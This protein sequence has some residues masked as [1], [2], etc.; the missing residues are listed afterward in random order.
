MEAGDHDL[1]FAPNRLAPGTYFV[2]VRAD[3]RSM[4]RTVIFVR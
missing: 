3:G 4:Q 2:Q 1:L